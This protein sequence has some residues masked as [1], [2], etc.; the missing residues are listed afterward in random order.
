MIILFP[1]FYY[2]FTD[3]F[4]LYLHQTPGKEEFLI[5]NVPLSQYMYV[6][7]NLCQEEVVAIPLVIVHRKTIQGK[8]CKKWS[9]LF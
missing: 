8:D 1:P 2:G 7:E 5:Q 9:Y 3:F 4:F 6:R